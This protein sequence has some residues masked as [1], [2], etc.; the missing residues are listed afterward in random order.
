MGQHRAIAT[1]LGMAL[2][3]TNDGATFRAESAEELVDKLRADSFTPGASRADFMR[4][5]ASRA[6]VLCGALVRDESPESFVSD[7][8][9]AGLLSI[10]N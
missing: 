8:L 6:G 3:F 9:A 5:S 2:Y 4:E 1:L 7:L 10:A